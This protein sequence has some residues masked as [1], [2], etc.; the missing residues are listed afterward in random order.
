M[1]RVPKE[2]IDQ[3]NS[4]LF[5]NDKKDIT[6]DSSK[7]ALEFAKSQDVKYRKTL[8]AGLF[9]EIRAYKKRIKLE[10]KQNRLIGND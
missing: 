4:L 7:L 1:K 5:I 6:N 8:Y 9:I 10:K 2:I 3:M